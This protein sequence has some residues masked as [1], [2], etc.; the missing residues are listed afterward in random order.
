MTIHGFPR[1]LAGESEHLNAALAKPFPMGWPEGASHMDAEQ[2]TAIGKA[3]INS[4]H[5]EILGYKV[6]FLYREK[7]KKRDRVVL[8]VASRVTS[9]LAFYSGLDFLIEIN[10]TAWK[11]LS[12]AQRVALIDHEL[13]HCSVEVDEETGEEKAVLVSHDVEE[14]GAIVERWG[15]WKEDLR[16][17]GDSVKFAQMNLFEARD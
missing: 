11:D 1:A 14:F 10:W 6:G 12:A 16:R 15:L 17:F 5:S 9:K 2:P 13:S 4:I 3:L 7:M 8:G